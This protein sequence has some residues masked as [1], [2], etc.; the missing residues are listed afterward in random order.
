MFKIENVINWIKQNITKRDIFMLIGIVGLYVLT[1]LI[2]LERLPI[3]SDEGIYIQWARTAWKDATMRF[4]SLTDG[5]QPLQT[6]GTIP[7][8]KLFPTQ[9]L[10]AGRLF[11]VSTGFI[12][13]SGMFTT[14]WYLFNKRT[15]Y[16]VALLYIFTPYF[17]FYDR[18][19]L[20]DSAIN[21][22]TIWMFFFSILLARTR[23]LDV[24]LVLG[25]ITGFA[26]LGKSS[27]RVYAG[28]MLVASIFIVYGH[29][30]G[31]VWGMLKRLKSRLM[32]SESK[33]SEL[34]SFFLLYGVTMSVALLM[35]NVQRLSPYMHYV[36]QKNTTFVL[37]LPELIQQPFA[38]F[39]HNIVNLPYYIFSEMGYVV[40][41]LGI[42]GMFLLYKKDRTLS[43]YL[44]IWFA[45]VIIALSFVAK[46]LF[47]RY[48]LSLGGLLL[49][50][51]AYLL[52][53]LKD[54]RNLWGVI[55]VIFL[56]IG[57]TNYAIWFRPYE[58]P[59]PSI[60]RG[61]YLEGWPAGIGTRDIVDF[62][63][64]QAKQKP[65]YLVAQ[66]DFGMSGDVLRTFIH[67][68]EP[69][70]VRAYWPLTD[71]KLAENQSEIGANNV[72]VVYSHC[73]EPAYVGNDVTDDDRC[74]LFEERKPL[75]LIKRFEKPGNKNAIYLFELLPAVK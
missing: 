52:G 71:E 29:A 4:I 47:P 49:L 21:A 60:D 48:V 15:A 36:E 61:Q 56:S 68:G 55:G 22:G 45:T 62:A 54:K 32:G 18:I 31:G 17:I 23:R 69:I 7:F 65:V 33:V 2:N 46:V 19:A 41:A 14:A 10:F 57:M 58:L 51:A 27:V 30:D 39:P 73:K 5:R 12:A 59:F 66:G 26:M 70:H 25:C 67:E 35:Y 63:R 3:F 53:Q 64:E 75:K 40:A 24:A 16:I 42:L 44:G 6:W 20:V 37:T 9:T 38:Y 43:I 34:V 8:L 13:L 11:S 74:Y 28:L 72:F 50:P 1:R